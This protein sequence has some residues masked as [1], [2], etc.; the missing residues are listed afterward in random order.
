MIESLSV[1]NFRCYGSL[2]VH[3]LKRVNVIVGRNASGKTTLLESIFLAAGGSP[4]IALRFRLWRGMGQV[5]QISGDRRSFESL[6]KDLFFSLDQTKRISLLI[7][8]SEENTASLEISYS[9]QTVLAVP[10]DS[11]TGE[12]Q[13]AVYPLDFE[14]KDCTGK[15]TKG[16]IKIGGA[17]GLEMEAIIDT[18]KCALFAPGWGIAAPQEHAQRFSDLSKMNQ[19]GPVIDAVKEEFPI[20]KTLSVELSGGVGVIHASVDFLPGKVPV[21]VVSNG[22]MKFLYLLLAIT[23]NRKGVVLIDE[24]EDGFYYDRLSQIWSSLLRF[25]TNQECQLFATT[26][27]L[28]CLRAILPAVEKH[29]EDFS[30]IRTTRED[31]KVGVS[32]FSGKALLSLIRQGFDPRE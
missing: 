6:W 5:F 9:S 12:P 26:H 20:I 25:C 14:W 23:S 16:R 7:V 27:S 15:V 30:L 21:G 18:V 31:G 28:E 2:E 1:K 29:Q 13:L 10:L 24:I 11:S 22:V 19:E 32:V 17:R 8:G 3:G 4:E